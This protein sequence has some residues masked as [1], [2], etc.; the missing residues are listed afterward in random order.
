M[1]LVVIGHVDAGKSTLMGHLLVKLGRVDQRTMRKYKKESAQMGKG[2]FSFA[3]VLDGHQEERERGIT[4]DV[5]TTHFS[6]KNREVTLLD[7]PGHRDFIPNMISGAAQADAAILVVPAKIGEFETSFA[8]GGQTKEHA[9]LIRSFG[10]KQI[11]VAINK[12]D[13]VGWSKA[14]YDEVSKTVVGFLRSLGY[15]SK[16][17]TLVPVSGLSGEN[18]TEAKSV[19]LTHWYKGK[20]LA[21][22]ID[23]VRRR[24]TTTTIT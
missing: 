17:I 8:K 1:N 14:R 18:L 22:A 6:T 11:V 23:N 21:E 10:V 13:L 16:Q 19:D 24:T 4:V 15:K 20:S 9:T 7:A 5:A 12:M 2:S 3:W